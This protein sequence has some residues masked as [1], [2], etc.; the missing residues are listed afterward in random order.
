MKNVVCFDIETIPGKQSNI[1]L[2]KEVKCKRCEHNPEL[3]PKQKKPYCEECADQYALKWPTAQIVCI[4]AKIVDGEMFCFCDKDEYTVLSQAY[5]LLEG[6][7]P[8][9]WIGFNSTEFDVVQLKMRGLINQ[10]PFVD[11][12]P[13]GKYDRNSIDLYDQL[14]QGK[15]NKQQ[16]ATLE[17]FAAMLG[18]KDLLYGSGR[19]VGMWYLNNE[20]DEIAKHNQGDVL[21]TE[22]LFLEVYQV[23]QKYRAK[24]V[25]KEIMVDEE[26]TIKF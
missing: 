19:D 12:L 10:V 5:D 9:P 25:K 1:D 26:E 24:K 8:S 23:G 7:Q 16:S 15:W 13:S 18:F 3:H 22:R 6:L 2:Y 20:L 17:L 21:A 4:T 14:T 11:I